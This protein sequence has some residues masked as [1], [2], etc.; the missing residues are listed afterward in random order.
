MVSKPGG[1]DPLYRATQAG[2]DVV[3]PRLGASTLA[4]AIQIGAPV[5]WRKCLR[6]LKAT[7]G[8]VEQVTDEEILDA[9]AIVDAVGIGAEPASCATVAGLRKL[10]TAGVI[11]SDADVCGILTGHVLKDPEIVVRYHRGELEDIEAA[12]RNAP[13]SVPAELDAILRALD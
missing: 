7:Q 3:E 2:R 8:V 9:K 1:L 12:H 11:A 10:A 6:G 13:I 5:S 4:T